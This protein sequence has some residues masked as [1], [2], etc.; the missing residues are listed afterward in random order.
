MGPPLG[1]GHRQ[2]RVL[3]SHSAAGR[4]GSGL[5]PALSARA[6]PLVSGFASTVQEFAG[7]LFQRLE[8]FRDAPGHLVSI[9]GEFDAADLLRHGL[10]LDELQGRR[11]RSARFRSRSSVPAGGRNALCTL[12]DGS[13]TRRR[14]STAPGPGR[15]AHAGG[16]RIRRP[17]VL[18]GSCRRGPPALCVMAKTSFWV[19]RMISRFRFRCSPCNASWRL[20]RKRVGILPRFVE[21]PLTFGVGLVRGLCQERCTLLIE[22][23]VLVLKV[24][25]LLLRFRLLRLGL[26][27]LGGDPFLSFVDGVED[28]LVEE[29]LQQPHQDE[30]VDRLGDRR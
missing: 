9:D 6:W 24:V 7:A 22:G 23:L 26:R 2:A 11:F 20:A 27:E 28:G 1:R 12:T 8:I 16:G 13:R 4:F 21:Q 15:S 18:R 25:A 29:S 3:G 17:C 5:G 19:Q 30:E 14:S 10:E